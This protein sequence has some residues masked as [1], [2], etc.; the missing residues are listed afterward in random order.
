MKEIQTFDDLFD[1]LWDWEAEVDDFSRGGWVANWDR[2]NKNKARPMIWNRKK[3]IHI[4]GETPQ[5][6]W[7][8]FQ[9]YLEEKEG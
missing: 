6:T 1:A 4:V 2:T 5:E 8:L 9:K 3:D 7:D